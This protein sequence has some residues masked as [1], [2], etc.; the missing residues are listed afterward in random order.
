M[1]NLAAEICYRLSRRRVLSRQLGDAGANP[2]SFDRANYQTWRQSELRVQYEKN[3][4][5]TA[6]E[7]KDV[8]D[9]G[10]GGGELSFFAAA[11]GAASVT[12]FEVSADQ[13]RIALD[14]GKREA[15]QPAPDFVLGEDLES[16]PFADNS[17]D[18][19]LCFD[20]LEHI[21]AYEPIIDEWRRVLRPGGQVLI[22]WVPYYHP[23]GHHVES[24]VPLPW[25]HAF[26]PDKAIIGACARIYDMP[27]FVPRVWD[28]DESGRKKPNKWKHL[29]ELP[30]LN[31]LTIGGFESTARKAGFAFQRRELQPITSSRAAR[32]ISSLLSRLP[33]AREF[34][35][36]CTI[37]ELR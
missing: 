25:V 29:T 20:V 23:Y 34:F 19:V 18:V 15:V 14:N 7:G 37:Y 13:H 17:F 27:E 2:R 9:F 12:G 35:T 26:L 3:F 5:T 4:S 6:L 21:L 30:T 24:L 10:C 32:T 1:I 33:I 22:W 28:V 11:S 31:K 36:A 16:L 8:L